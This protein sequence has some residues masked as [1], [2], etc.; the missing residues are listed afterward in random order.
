MSEIKD[1]ALTDLGRTAAILDAKAPADAKAFKAWLAHIAQLVAEAASEG[2][3]LGFGGVK[4]S[5]T[6]K[7]TLAEISKL[8]AHKTF[9][10][11][12]QRYVGGNATLKVTPLVVSLM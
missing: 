10:D 3:F 9:R 1:R 5:D 6:E 12:L 7:A 11:H 2:G 4:V 8:W